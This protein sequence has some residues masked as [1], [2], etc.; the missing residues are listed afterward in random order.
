MKCDVNLD[1]S[2][3]LLDLYRILRH[4][5]RIE[6]LAG[7]VGVP[8]TALWG[9]DANGDMVINILDLMKCINK[10]IGRYDPKVGL[11]VAVVE[12]PGEVEVV[13]G[14]GVKVPVGVEVEEPLSGVLCRLRYDGEVLSLG[15]PELGER[16]A[17]MELEWG[18]VGDELWVLV[19]SLVGEVI[20]AGV[21]EVVWLPFA[22]A[23][24]A[25]GQWEV[26]FEQ[27][28]LFVDDER[29]VFTEA[30]VVQMRSVA[31]VPVE[32]SLSQ[33][34]PNPFNP[35]TEI[36]YGLP[37]AAQVRLEVFNLLGQRVATLVD[38]RQ[39]AGYH[40]VRWD[41]AEMASGV[42]FYRIQAGDFTA[43]RRMMLMK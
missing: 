16:S 38:E 10:S 5:V 15:R 8:G 29:I 12:V 21:G 11:P 41:A 32:Y 25:E 17:G 14:G 40:R 22:V 31:L 36:R 24:G 4:I 35:M 20:R 23:A 42:Y 26:A 39:E 2:V 19:Y 3:T 33:N 28:V 1:T 43:T 7:P 18:R 27:S 6:M 34:Y 9:A 37:E 13:A 30:A